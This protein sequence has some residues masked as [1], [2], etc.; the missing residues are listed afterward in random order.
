MPE[1]DRY[2]LVELAQ[3]LERV[4]RHYDEWRFHMVY[5]TLFDYVGDLSAVYLDVLKDRLYADAP[6]SVSRRSAQTV[7]ARILGVLVRVLAPILSFTCEEV[8]DFM[9]E[10]LRDAESVQLS[11]WPTVEMPHDADAAAPPTYAI[12]LETRE[13]RR[14]RRSRRR[15]PAR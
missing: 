12:V 6:D 13:R 1:L 5:R 2:A 10:T 7:L 15:A 3:V 14:T 8:W 11:D 9:P 4:T